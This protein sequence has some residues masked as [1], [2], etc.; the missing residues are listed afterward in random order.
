MLLRCIQSENLKLRHSIIYLACILLPIIPAIMGTFNYLQNIEILKS[1]WYS[2]WTQITLFYSSFFYAPLVGLYASYLWRLEH[3][4]H[5]WNTI[6]SSPVSIPCL[7]FAKLA[8]VFKITI[9][10]QLWISILYF[11]SGKFCHLPGF[12]PPDILIW[13][14]RGTLAAL[15]IGS[16]QLFLS[17][18]IRNFAIPIGIALIGSVP[19]MIITK[20]SFEFFWPYSL[21]LVGMNSNNSLDALTGIQNIIFFFVSVLAFFCLFYLMAIIYLKKTDVKS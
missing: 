6:M 21:M 13:I 9:I 1:G 11:I 15:A 5:N 12:F 20:K 17:M 8:I 14:A 4:G 3:T 10:T 19:A 2:L 18:I 16:L 7:Y